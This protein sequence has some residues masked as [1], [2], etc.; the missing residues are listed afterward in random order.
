MD[1]REILSKEK[2][3]IE[4]IIESVVETFNVDKDDIL[5]VLDS[6][7]WLER[8]K[9]PIVIEFRG[10][11]DENEEYPEYYYYD[12]YFDDNSILKKLK[13]FNERLGSNVVVT[14]D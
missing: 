11:L 13:D 10:R 12:I 8:D 4:Q 7:D 14:L 9:E 5:F 6:N 2:L 1:S 3:S